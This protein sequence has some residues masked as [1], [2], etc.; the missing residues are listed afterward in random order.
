MRDPTI[1]ITMTV[2]KFKNPADR[3]DGIVLSSAVTERSNYDAVFD[4][5]LA[6]ITGPVLVLH[7][8]DDPCYVTPPA[9]AER[10]LAALTAAKPKTLIMFEGG[11]EHAS[12]G[13]CGA[14]SHHGFIDIE[15]RVTDA[16]TA[17]VKDP[18]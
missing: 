10:L 13:D 2:P 14:K 6:G 12:G 1:S 18:K 7:H 17:W 4:A 15:E 3:P 11:G 9:G 16:M 5:D 8:K